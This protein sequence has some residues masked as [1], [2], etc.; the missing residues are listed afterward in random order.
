MYEERHKHA[1]VEMMSLTE[2]ANARSTA[3][4]VSRAELTAR[5]EDAVDQLRAREEDVKR[6]RL[7]RETE[8]SELQSHL[9]K[10]DTKLAEQTRRVEAL[11]GE[12]ASLE[13]RLH[14]IDSR[15]RS[16]EAELNSKIQSLEDD[17]RKARHALEEERTKQAVLNDQRDSA[18]SSK[19]MIFNENR[20]LRSQLDALQRDKAQQTKM[21]SE[22]L[23]SLQADYNELYNK[24]QG[25]QRFVLCCFSSSSFFFF[26]FSCAIFVFVA[27]R[28]RQTR[29][30]PR[31][32]SANQV[33]SRASGRAAVAHCPIAR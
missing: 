5:Y 20:E 7:Q 33:A 32:T 1:S 14:S 19:K 30:I 23:R 24:L 31:L 6:L 27:S 22:Q 17:L 28:Q 3:S 10:S 4:E 15:S 16:T 29:S 12:K 18:A 11:L 2:T 8:V 21:L 25:V 9:R 13:A 26:V